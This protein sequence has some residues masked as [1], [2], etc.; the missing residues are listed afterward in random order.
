[1]QGKRW[2]GGG[3]GEREETSGS[4]IFQDREG[5]NLSTQLVRVAGTSASAAMATPTL[6]KLYTHRKQK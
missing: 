1:M 6:G 5:V 2:K 4:L 3:V